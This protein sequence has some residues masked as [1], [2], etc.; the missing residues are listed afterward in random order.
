MTGEE[1]YQRGLSLLGQ[2]GREDQVQRYFSLAQKGG[3]DVASRFKDETSQS[4]ESAKVQ[5]R[6]N[7]GNGATSTRKLPV[8]SGGVNAGGERLMSG[9]KEPRTEAGTPELADGGA[10]AAMPTGTTGDILYH[11]GTAW[12]VLNAPTAD[13]AL[14][15]Q[16]TGGLQWQSLVDTTIC[17][18]EGEKSAKAL[19]IETPT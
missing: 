15:W 11:N 16:T 17:T 4:I 14:T 2:E 3:V 1:A 19:I 6:S 18:E 5:I 7:L 9:P 10:P 12:I 8:S 13:S